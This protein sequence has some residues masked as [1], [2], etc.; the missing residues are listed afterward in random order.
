MH[1]SYR[2][3]GYYAAHCSSCN[4]YLTTL[5]IKYLASSDFA[6]IIHSPPGHVKNQGDGP[7]GS[8]DSQFIKDY[9][10]KQDE[11]APASVMIADGAYSGEDNV[12]AA[13][14]KMQNGS[15]QILPGKK[16]M[17]LLLIFYLEHLVNF[18]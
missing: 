15:L 2:V 11:D 3:K 8:S 10:A 14:E 7:H 5:N 1:C 13:E 4:G 18:F 9:F 12:A 17:T 6:R 16:P